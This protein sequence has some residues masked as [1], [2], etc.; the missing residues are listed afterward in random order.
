MSF[1]KRFA[2]WMSKNYPDVPVNMSEWTHM[3]GGRDKGMDSALVTANVMYEDLSV[4]NVISWQHWIAVSEVN[5][6]D[7]LIY[8][9]LDDKTFEM[10]KRYYVTG[11]FSKYG[12]TGSVR[13]DAACDDPELRLLA[14]K[15]DGGCAV[16]V[17]NSTEKEKELSLPEQ[18]SAVKSAVT[19]DNNDL[20]EYDIADPGH[21]KITPRSVTTIILR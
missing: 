5:Y 9:N 16:I 19:D 8:I 17:I 12:P 7:G 6:C 10:T 15:Y 14:F 1:L 18:Y 11:N 20:S 2:K 13:V 4:L 3:Q 21:I